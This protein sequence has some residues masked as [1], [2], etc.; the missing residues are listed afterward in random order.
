MANVTITIP[1]EI[2]PRLSAAM[3]ATFAVAEGET[4]LQAFK[5]LTAEYWR[6]VLVNFESRQAEAEA[7]NTQRVALEQARAQAAEDSAGIA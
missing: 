5:R 4:D 3:H 1:N 2:V 6:N 7:W